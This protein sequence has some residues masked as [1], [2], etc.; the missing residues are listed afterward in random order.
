MVKVPVWK[1]VTLSYAICIQRR[2]G[3]VRGCGETG[4]RGRRQIRTLF[5]D[6]GFQN[7][8]AVDGT[9]VW[10]RDGRGLVQMR[11]LMLFC[12]GLFGCALLSG[13]MGSTVPQQCVS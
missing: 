2:N 3:K 9:T 6:D 13:L 10:R 5:C 11:I 1:Q 7:T 12:G 8:R 4:A